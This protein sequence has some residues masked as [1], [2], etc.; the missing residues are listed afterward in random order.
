MRLK[1]KIKSLY[2]VL[3]LIAFAILGNYLFNPQLWLASQPETELSV[4]EEAA[5]IQQEKVE[6][7]KT[8]PKF[9]YS[10]RTERSPQALAAASGKLYVSYQRL[11]MVDVL[12]Y[13]GVRLK[14][15][16]PYPKGPINA[17]S[18]AT[19]RWNNLYLVDARNHSILVFDEELT[20][21]SFFPPDRMNPADVASVNVPSG[22]TINR[23]NVYVADMGSSMAKS[24]MM[25]GNFV[26]AVPG[27]GKTEREPWHPIDIEITDD[28]RIL[29]S[30][31]KNRNISVF[32]C[33]GNFAHE[34]A[35]PE[36]RDRLQLPGGLAIDS[37]GRVHVLDRGSQKIFVYDNYGRFLFTYGLTGEG[38]LRLK[39]PMGIAIDKEKNLIFIADSGNRKIDVWS[40]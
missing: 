8:F 14:F 18:L 25:D 23:S 12:D 39:S 16:D 2:A 34:F 13:Q 31:L 10:I 40:L 24:F 7:L 1:N 22:I 15:F 17:V 35:I 4:I 21:Q 6:A 36:G 20:F 5:L 27:T 28:G 30:D 3:L 32:N 33:I 11:N 38:P 19:D 29:V 37:E 26:L 9:Q